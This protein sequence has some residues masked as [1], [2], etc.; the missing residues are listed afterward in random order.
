MFAIDCRFGVFLFLQ[1]AFLMPVF[2]HTAAGHT[3]PQL[4]SSGDDEVYHSFFA[5]RYA[6]FRSGSLAK[7]NNQRRSERK[8]LLPVYHTS[9]GTH[10]VDDDDGAAHST[11]R[12]ATSHFAGF[13]SGPIQLGLVVRKRIVALWSLFPPWVEMLF[14]RA[15]G[16]VCSH[17]QFA[18]LAAA[19]AAAASLCQDKNNTVPARCVVRD[20]F[21]FVFRPTQS[22]WRM[23]YTCAVPKRC[24][25]RSF[26]GLEGQ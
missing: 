19:A 4:Q 14:L 3:P 1:L 2:P 17:L 22:V 6:D 15:E 12:L 23:C 20:D 8:T 24:A 21:D 9:R 26:D 7:T 18:S 10:D 5:F 11:H 16:T 25:T 13:L